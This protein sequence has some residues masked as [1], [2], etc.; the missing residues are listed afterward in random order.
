MKVD[1]GKLFLTCSD[2]YGGIHCLVNSDDAAH[3]VKV[4][5]P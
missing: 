3:P 4:H 2:L 1:Q 5:S